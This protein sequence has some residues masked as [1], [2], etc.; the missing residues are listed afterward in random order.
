MKTKK[1]RTHVS[2]ELTELNMETVQESMAASLSS[3]GR[4]ALLDCCRQLQL[5]VYVMC[6]GGM[7]GKFAAEQP[8]DFYIDDRAATVY[9]IETIY[10]SVK[11]LVLYAKTLGLDPHNLRPS[12]ELNMNSFME[13]H[14]C[15]V[16]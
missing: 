10:Q 6:G 9:P 5:T 2:V 11:V 12:L 16:F 13:H 8:A 4:I 1:H 7:V 15:G 14:N 3:N